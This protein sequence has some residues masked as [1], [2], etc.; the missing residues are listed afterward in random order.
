MFQLS[1]A[2]VMRAGNTRTHQYSV[3]DTVGDTVGRHCLFLPYLVVTAKPNGRI[4]G[5]SQLFLPIVLTFY[6]A[7]LL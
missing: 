6:S 3:G 5:E 2:W 7:V 4:W 1:F